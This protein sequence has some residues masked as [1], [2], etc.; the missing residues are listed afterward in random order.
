MPIASMSACTVVGPT[1]A[2]PRRFSSSD[3]AVLSSEVVGTSAKRVGS[4]VVALVAVNEGRASVA[5]GVTDDLHRPVV[6]AGG[7]DVG[8][9]L[10]LARDNRQ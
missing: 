2:N 7:A 10:R 6:G 3:S 9:E 1:N 4:G 5:V 8:S